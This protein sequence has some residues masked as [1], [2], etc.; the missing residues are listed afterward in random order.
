MYGGHGPVSVTRVALAG[1]RRRLARRQRP[2]RR[3][4]GCAAR[5]TPRPAAAVRPA[6]AVRSR[7]GALRRRD[8]AA[9][10]SNSAATVSRA[11]DASSLEA[12]R[13][14]FFCADTRRLCPLPADHA[15]A[16]QRRR[17]ARAIEHH[18]HAPL[19][20]VR[21]AF[22]QRWRSAR[23][24][25]ATCSSARSS[26]VKIVNSFIGSTAVGG[27]ERLDHRLVRHR[28]A[29]HPVEVRQAAVDRR[30]AVAI[31]RRDRRR[32]GTVPRRRSSRRTG[33]HPASPRGTRVRRGRRSAADEAVDVGALRLPVQCSDFPRP[34]PA[35]SACDASRRRRRQ[36]CLDDSAPPRAADAA[37]QRQARAALR[38][39]S[40]GSAGSGRARA[41]AR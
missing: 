6:P 21:D 30:L 24:A 37:Q 4:R 25:R 31:E 33:P 14:A 28:G 35:P 11:R 3:W 7:P 34:R 18:A 27:N 23:A 29:R 8:V 40:R 1:E 36:R 19:L 12:S 9:S 16:W 26:V 15:L 13:C 10:R 32:R 2:E 5:E 41:S 17:R 20:L 22:H 39:R 38:P